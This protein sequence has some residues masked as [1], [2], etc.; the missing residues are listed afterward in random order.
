M[1]SSKS[2]KK[3]FS[4][5]SSFAILLCALFIPSHAVVAS[6]Y[7]L[8]ADGGFEGATLDSG[9]THSDKNTPFASIST[10]EKYAGNQSL[11]LN[12]DSG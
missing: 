3:A 11:Y 4:V 12:T 6:D 7:N 5:L 8:I 10:S 9:W 1:K 2:F